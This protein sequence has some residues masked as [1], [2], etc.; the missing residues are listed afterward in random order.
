MDHYIE[1]EVTMCDQCGGEPV[2]LGMLGDRLHLRCRQC[3]WQWSYIG[4]PDCG[5]PNEHKGH[6][7]CQYPEDNS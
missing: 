3:G 2:L 6:M 4:C 7:G 5:E 1:E